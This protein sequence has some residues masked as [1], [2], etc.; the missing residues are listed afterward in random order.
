MGKTK[1]KSKCGRFEHS[2]A[3]RPVEKRKENDM[4]SMFALLL[5]VN[6]RLI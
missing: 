2:L 6:I 5:V 4:L 3:N 1:G